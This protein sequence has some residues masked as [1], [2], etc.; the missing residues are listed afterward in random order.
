MVTSR[1]KMFFLLFFI[2]FYFFG[3]KH[4]QHLM[5]VVIAIKQS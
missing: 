3:L 5:F 1:K 4:V 2:I